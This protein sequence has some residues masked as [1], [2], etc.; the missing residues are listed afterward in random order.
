MGRPHGKWPT[1]ALGSLERTVDEL[2]E[3]ERAARAI[4][5]SIVS[6]DSAAALRDLSDVRVMALQC[7]DNLVQA[8]IGKYQQQGQA[9]QWSK[10][11]ATEDKV[12]QTVAQVM[13]TRR[14]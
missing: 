8:R 7:V 2:K 10:P 4:Q 13:A 6:G 5:D 11:V 3:L 9:A 1:Y 12:T 14:S